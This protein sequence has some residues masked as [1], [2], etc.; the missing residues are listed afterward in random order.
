MKIRMLNNCAASGKSLAAGDTYESPQDISDSDAQ[1]LIRCRRAVEKDDVPASS[2]QPQ[3]E[4]HEES[5]E[6]DPSQGTKKNKGGK[7]R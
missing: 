1:A 3:A 6:A 7:K 4:A 5:G 2:L